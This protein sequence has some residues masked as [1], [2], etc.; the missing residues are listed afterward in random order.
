[1]SPKRRPFCALLAFYGP[2]IAFLVS[3]NFSLAARA[4]LALEQACWAC[5]HLSPRFSGSFCPAKSLLQPPARPPGGT[6]KRA[7]R[8]EP[9]PSAGR[10]RPPASP[11]S[12]LGGAK[13]G[14]R[15]DF[16]LRGIRSGV[17]VAPWKT[18]NF[19]FLPSSGQ[20]FFSPVGVF[21]SPLMTRS[22]G[23]EGTPPP[24]RPSGKAGKARKARKA[25]EAWPLRGTPSV[26]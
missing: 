22:G 4:R 6:P 17:Q 9:T 10:H 15:V 26:P 23:E 19:Q 12:P 8:N 25:R 21:F 5:R 24:S 7:R 13:V 11:W 14:F 3:Q 2:K 1:M 18:R 16:R 20:V